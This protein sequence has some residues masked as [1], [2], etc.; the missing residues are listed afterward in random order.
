MNASPTQVWYTGDHALAAYEVSQTFIV[1]FFGHQVVESVERRLVLSTQ[2]LK[3]K[4]DER[5]S[6]ER[7][8]QP[9]RHTRW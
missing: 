4:E 1:V 2:Q 7:N 8:K 6:I 3:E 5:M 9:Q